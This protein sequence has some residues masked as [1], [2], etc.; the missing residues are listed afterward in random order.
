MANPLGQLRRV[1]SEIRRAERISKR[2]QKLLPGTKN[3]KGTGN[4]EVDNSS[5]EEE[6][7]KKADSKFI[8]SFISRKGDEDINCDLF[9]YVELSDAACWVMADGFDEN[10]YGDEAAKIVLESIISQFMEKPTFTRKFLNKI[11]L[12]AQKKLEEVKSKS[13]KKRGMSA[14][15]VVFITNYSSC[16]FANVGNARVYLI[17]DELVK[18]RTRDNSISHLMYEMKQLEYKEIRFHSQRNKLTQSL[19]DIENI[20][21]EISK[22]IFLYDGDRVILMTHGS[23][24]NLDES[25]IEVELSKSESVGNWIGRLENKIKSNNESKLSNYTVAGIFINQIVDGDDPDKKRS[26]LKIFCIIMLVIGVFMIIF[27][28]YRY[29]RE[30]DNIYEKAFSYENAGLQSGKKGDWDDAVNQLGMSKGE[31]EKL[32]LN[33]EKSNFVKRAIFSADIN[34]RN[35]GNQ[36]KSLDKQINDI[37]K[38]KDAFEMIKTGDKAFNNNDFLEATGIYSN[39]RNT[40]M[41]LKGL[42]YNGYKDTIDKLEED[43]ITSSALQLGYKQKLDADMQAQNGDIDDA[44]RNYLGS[45]IIFLKHGKIDLM[46]EVTEKYNILEKTKDKKFNEA[47]LYEKKS[48]EVEATDI[49]SAIIHMQMAKS[50]YGEMKDME[51]V[52][53]CDVR[54]ANLE[55]MKSAINDESKEYLK[56]ATTYAQQGEYERA[57]ESIKKSK[58]VST[59]LKDDQKLADS[60]QKEGDILAEGDKF[61]IAKE[62]YEE[63]YGVSVNTNNT[64]QQEYLKGKSQAMEKVLAGQKIEQEGDTLMS[65]KKYK[66]ARKMFKEAITK[67]ETLKDDNYFDRGKYNKIMEIIKEKEKKAWKKSNWIPFF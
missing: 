9:G 43:I 59:K 24:E 66:E 6:T 44:I 40:I 25:E 63:G 50:I 67:Y 48:Y 55:E 15:V 52:S 29:K 35:V 39:A 5:I 42:E 31:Y 18:F 4:K 23:W 7:G 33:K 27:I 46:T 32:K 36:I 11:I 20:S 21:V 16:I 41:E 30:R 34:N 45:K 28:L 61:Q 51:R 10:G 54:I 17:R 3:S 58:D 13:R 22:E 56:E 47:F 64:I 14:S 38:L 62:K 26:Y 60:L 57:L 65:D 2:T 49:S 37:N 53:A 12:N 8:T 19:G 1:E